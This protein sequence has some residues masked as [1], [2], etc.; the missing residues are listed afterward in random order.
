[1]IPWRLLYTPTKYLTSLL[2]YVACPN[3]AAL[4][5]GLSLMAACCTWV[6]HFFLHRQDAV[7]P[8]PTRVPTQEEQ[9]A[10]LQQQLRRHVGMSEGKVHMSV[11]EGL[12]MSVSERVKGE[13]KEKAGL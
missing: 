10:W 9:I 6:V 4:P 13:Q 5:L 8:A 11:S 12:D 2:P 7:G 1:M 3:K